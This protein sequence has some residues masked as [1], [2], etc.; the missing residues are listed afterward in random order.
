MTIIFPRVSGNIP[1][2]LSP[3]NYCDEHSRKDPEIS[4]WCPVS[5]EVPAATCN[6]EKKGLENFFVLKFSLGVVR[7]IQH[8]EGS[9]IQRVTSVIQRRPETKGKGDY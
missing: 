7:G 6:K 1:L 4:R 3:R 9:N 8:P 5:C 2:F